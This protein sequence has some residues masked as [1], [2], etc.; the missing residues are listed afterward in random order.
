[1]AVL[2]KD[3]KSNGTFLLVE[4]HKLDP[5]PLNEDPKPIEA[6]L[7]WHI[8]DTIFEGNSI[9]LDQ[10]MELK[11]EFTIRKPICKL[12]SKVFFPLFFFIFHDV[13]CF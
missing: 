4:S 9:G 11:G 1:M 2:V 7:K 3:P 5:R 13:H 12:R 8:H 6:K 10:K